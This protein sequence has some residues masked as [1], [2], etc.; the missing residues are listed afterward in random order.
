[1]PDPGPGQDGPDRDL[2]AQYEAYPYPERDPRDE[3]KRLVVG[4]PSHLREIDHWVFGAARPADRPLRVL[5][6]GCGTGDAAIM[7]AAQMRR[8]GRPGHLTCIDRSER[9]LD[10]AR[11]RA[12]ARGLNTLS[13]QRRSLLELPAPDL[14]PF[15]YI[16]CCGVLHHLPD[17]PATLRAL[18]R[19]LAP[20]GGI[21]LM[22]YAPHGRTGVYMLQEALALLAP[23]GEPPPARLDV[24][25]RVMR[26]L[27]ATAWLRANANFADH[28]TGGDAGLYDL[29]LNPRDVA[30]TIADVLTLLDQAGL[31]GGGADGAVPLRPRPAAAGPAAARRR[32]APGAGAAG[33][34]GGGAGREHEHPRGLRG[35]GGRD[36]AGARPAGAGPGAAGA[37]DADT[38]DAA[39]DRAGR[40]AAAVVRPADRPAAAAAP[41]ARDP[42]AGRRP[43]DGGRDRR[44]AGRGAASRGPG[45]RPSGRRP[46]GR[47]PRANR[48]LARAADR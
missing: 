42:G 31:E 9:A 3:A 36:A 40:H 27:P 20:G 10:I 48:L 11:A 38:R 34:A 25:R 19:S 43:A 15:D 8:A 16:D 4:S 29:L 21:G 1:M 5:V 14:G 26:H 13:F 28:L 41:G 32:G 12:A 23:A 30:Y 22:V 24:A 46:I 2:L 39:P 44:G 18:E 17:P 35:A 47:C 7:L 6:A 37:R 33:G 45:S